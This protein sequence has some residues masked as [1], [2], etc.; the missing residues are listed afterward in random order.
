MKT[1]A[2]T[3]ALG[4]LL[5]AAPAYAQGMPQPE[6]TTD[7]SAPP[8]TLP[9]DPAQPGAV[10]PPAAAAP[11]PTAADVDR[12]LTELFG[13]FAPY[14]AALA[15]L[16]KAVAAEDK[17]AVAAMIAYPITVKIDGA[18]K[19]FETE[20]AFIAAYDD[21]MDAAILLAIKNQTYETLFATDQGVMIGPSGQV[22]ISDVT[23]DGKSQGIKIIAINRT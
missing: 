10:P 22:W 18:P 14:K 19:V 1:I 12:K 15:D 16:Q 9:E 13:D 20:K 4:A 3:A 11:T 7:P 17:K 21:I 23:S 6:P 5:I 8:P 2:L